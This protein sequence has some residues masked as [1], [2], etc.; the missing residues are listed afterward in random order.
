MY[1]IEFETEITDKYIELKNYQNFINKHAKVIV[2]VEDSVQQSVLSDKVQEFQNLIAQRKN[3]PTVDSN[4]D[5]VK[6]CNEAD[7]DIF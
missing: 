6:L 7:S 2:L 3:Y 1:A 4:I 5:I